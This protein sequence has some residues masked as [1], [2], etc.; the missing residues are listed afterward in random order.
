MTQ[1]GNGLDD[2]ELVDYIGQYKTLSKSLKDYD[3]SRGVSIT[4]AKRLAEFLGDDIT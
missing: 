4:A 2:E 1:Q 3:N